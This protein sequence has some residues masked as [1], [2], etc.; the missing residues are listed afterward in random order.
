MQTAMN[1]FNTSLTC[2]QQE[3]AHHGRHNHCEQYVP[4]ATLAKAHTEM[5][6][7]QLL[8][9]GGVGMLLD[10]CNA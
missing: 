7:E 8:V 3:V 5:M 9:P 2:L 6:G 1:N 10:P 4:Q